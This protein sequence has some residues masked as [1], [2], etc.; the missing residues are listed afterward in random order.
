MYRKRIGFSIPL[1]AAMIS[2][3]LCVG[4]ARAYPNFGPFGL[5]WDDL[6]LQ[7]DPLP[8]FPTYEEDHPE[9]Y[10]LMNTELTNPT[11]TPST[12][13]IVPPPDPG[14]NVP[15]ST[16]SFFDIFVELTLDGNSYTASGQGQALLSTPDNMLPFT[17]V[18]DTEMLQLDISGGTLPSGMM[19]RESPTQQS[20]GQLTATNLGGGIY[21]I[22]SFF[23][24]FVELSLDGGDTWRPANKAL[25]LTSVPEPSSF[26]L[27]AVGGLLLY[28]VERRRR[29][30][31]G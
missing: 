7:D 16:T 13:G 29:D 17:T 18:F 2:C 30:S 23:D 22:D 27:L 1:A 6:F 14:N 15:S 10:Y 31:S 24:V 9:P 19:L 4:E 5:G 3:L 11:P 28:K 26:V 20:T 21:Q 8:F 25:H 12:P